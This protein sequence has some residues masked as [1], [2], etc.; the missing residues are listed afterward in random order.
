MN[1]LAIGDDKVH[2]FD[3]QVK[4]FL[5]ESSFPYTTPVESPKDQAPAALSRVFISEG[6]V[7]DLASLMKLRV[8]QKLAPGLRKEGYEDSAHA[9]SPTS[10]T[11]QQPRQ[12]APGRERDEPTHDPLRDDRLPPYAQPRPFDDP[13]AAAPRRPYPL[14][15]FP[16]PG[17][18]DEYEINR[19]PRG[20]PYGG[21]R[22]PLNI[23]ERD[24]YPQGLGPHDPLRAG[25]FGPS[26]GIGGGG[27]HPTF[28]DPLFG[29]P[30]GYDG[31]FVI[32]CFNSIYM[33]SNIDTSTELPQALATTLSVLATVRPISAVV[34]GS[35]V[36]VAV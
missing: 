34:H 9:A 4:D 1:G 28:D 33:R 11:Q 21:E 35:L 19:P 25:G 5:S 20:G 23:G 26:G 13:L 6:R 14:G 3:F 16:P 24:L 27:M 29:G 12:P 32:L 10:R 22:R 36:V 31:R 8:V 18:E 17:F 15:D 7:T 2:S 30:G